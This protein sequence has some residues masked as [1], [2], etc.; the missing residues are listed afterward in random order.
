MFC[1]KAVSVN[2]AIFE[3]HFMSKFMIKDIEKKEQHGKAKVRVSTN[4]TSTCKG[5]PYKTEHL[6]PQKS[7]RF[8]YTKRLK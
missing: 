6:F 1:L 2:P 8:C 7:F 5:R 3:V 4:L